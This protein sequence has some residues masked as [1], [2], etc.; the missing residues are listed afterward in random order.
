MGIAQILYCIVALIL[1]M[2]LDNML[3]NV[4]GCKVVVE[5]HADSGARGG[6]VVLCRDFGDCKPGQ[7]T[8]GPCYSDPSASGQVADPEEC[9]C[10][11]FFGL[12]AFRFHCSGEFENLC[13]FGRGTYRMG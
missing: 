3:K 6:G 5:G 11:G 1:G 12:T 4:C 8:Y 10:T 9:M 13:R 7:G 2:L